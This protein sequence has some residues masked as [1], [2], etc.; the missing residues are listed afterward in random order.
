MNSWT[1]AET[2]KSRWTIQNKETGRTGPSLRGFRLDARAAYSA[3]SPPFKARRWFADGGSDAEY[4]EICTSAIHPSACLSLLKAHSSTA[5]SIGHIPA[6]CTGFRPR[7]RIFI[8]ACAEPASACI[9]HNPPE[10]L[11][12]PTYQCASKK[13]RFIRDPHHHQ[14]SEKTQHVW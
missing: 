4:P 8:Q 2:K 12:I 3:V 7:Q 11:Q 14:T 1:G 13:K 5:G 6:P 9:C 10:Y